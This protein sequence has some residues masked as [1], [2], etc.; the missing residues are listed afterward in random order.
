MEVQN[1]LNCVFNDCE[2]YIFFNEIACC[3]RK[4]N[5]LTKECEI[6]NFINKHR[7]VLCIFRILERKTNFRQDAR[8]SSEKNGNK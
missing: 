5:I 1:S 6:S 2:V 4:K 8:Y 3:S 7:N